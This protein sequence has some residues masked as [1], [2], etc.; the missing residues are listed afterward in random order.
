MAIILIL[1]VAGLNP[2]VPLI[3]NSTVQLELMFVLSLQ[4]SD[5]LVLD[6]KEWI[7]LGL[8]NCK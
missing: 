5:Y 8:S 4:Y 6:I 7:V 1:G 2:S 3:K